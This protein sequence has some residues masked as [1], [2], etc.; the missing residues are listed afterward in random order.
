MYCSAQAHSS[1]EKAALL[2]SV[3][4]RKVEPTSTDENDLGIDG[5][6]LEKAI[7]KDL[8][9]GLV[10]FYVSDLEKWYEFQKLKNCFITNRFVP[11]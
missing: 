5:L 8:E 7:L 1:V 3:I 10:P 9:C 2:S 11:H 6:A 4:V